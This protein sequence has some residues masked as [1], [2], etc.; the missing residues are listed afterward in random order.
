MKIL[1]IKIN[2]LTVVDGLHLDRET[3]VEHLEH[4]VSPVTLLWFQAQSVVSYQFI[5]ATSL[6]IIEIKIK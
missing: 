5:F 2:I 1:K 6:L 3:P 4:S